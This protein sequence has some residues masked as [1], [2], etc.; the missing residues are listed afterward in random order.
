MASSAVAVNQCSCQWQKSPLMTLCPACHRYA[1]NGQEYTSV[2]RVIKDLLPPSYDGIDPVVLEIARLRGTF[3]DTYFSEWLIAAPLSMLSRQ[4]VKEMIA[5]QFPQDGE[6][7]AE[8]TV[9]RIE[10]LLDW[11]T[12]KGWKATG[13]QKTVYSDI[14]K[15]AG[16]MDVRTDGLIADVKCV[17]SL[18]PNYSLQL[19][20]Y[21]TY[22]AASSVAIIHVTKDKVRLV[23]YD[24]AKCRNQWINGLVWWQSKQELQ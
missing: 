24:N 23:E 18:Q 13:V 5:P 1:K 3:V 8:D 10:R 6:K 15:I 9:T 14:H 16:T 4:E 19:G 7:H 22:D 2:S 20:A 17:S 21:S 11:W 12:G